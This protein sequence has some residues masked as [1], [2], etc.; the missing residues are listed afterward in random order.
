MEARPTRILFVNSSV[1][2]GGAGKALLTM[3]RGFDPKVI[4]AHIVLPFDGVVGKPLKEAGATIH[5]NSN[6]AERFGKTAMSLPCFLRIQ[7]LEK[8]ANIFLFRKIAKDL[9]NLADEL[10]VDMIYANHLIHFPVCAMAGLWSG[11]KVILHSREWLSSFLE[12][13]CFRFFARRKSVKKVI[14]VSK[15]STKAYESTGKV[16]IVYDTIDGEDFADQTPLLRKEYGL[17]SKV[18][19]VG[20]MGRLIER[21]GVPLLMKAFQKAKED[22]PNSMLVIIGGNDPSLRKD[23]LAEYRK[24]AVHLGIDTQTLFTGFLS[25]PKPYLLDFDVSVMPSLDPEPFGL[26]PMEGAF[27]G[28]PAIIPDN[29]G[30]SEVMRDGKEALHFKAFSSTSLAEKIQLLGKH[31]ELRGN[32]GTQSK[33]LAYSRFDKTKE[34]FTQALLDVCK[35]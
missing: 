25:D 3:I 16:E 27:F 20:F 17:D 32:I 12:K 30:A 2:G 7:I 28:I 8:L 31:S 35:N 22:L 33:Q 10:D 29:S 26:V 24:M 14:A 23:L 21:K 19:I 4:E 6:L 13:L 9:A 34:G 15:V 18:F 1:S 5:Y 11:K